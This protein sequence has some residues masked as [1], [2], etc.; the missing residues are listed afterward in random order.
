MSM[1]LENEYAEIMLRLLL[2]QDRERLSFLRL[3]KD[4]KWD[5]FLELAQE[6]RVLLRIYDRLVKLGVHPA[7]PYQKAVNEERE[8]IERTIELMG[9]IS[10][11]C[12]GE[13]IDFIFMKNYQH[14]PDM[15]EDIDLL[16]MDQI[17]IADSVLTER[18]G[19]KPFKRSILNRIGGKTQYSIDGYP[20]D[21]EIHHGRLSPMGDQI[22]YPSFLMRNRKTIR[23]GNE[24]L[25]V[26]SREDQF[27]VQ[28]L[29]RVYGRF[30]IR[31]SEIIYAINAIY[32][33]TFDWD[34]IFKTA[35]SI[36]IFYGLRFY[37]NY[38]NL[39]YRN[40]MNKSLPLSKYKFSKSGFSFEL[41]FNKL[42]YR[43]PLITV[44]RKI[45]IKKILSDIRAS[46]WKPVGRIC[47]L[48]F[49]AAIFTYKSIV[50]RCG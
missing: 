7:G 12:E 48:P 44:A 10:D 46:R 19:A 40:V 6:N 45:Y 32:I 20:S 42:H 28:V 31:I 13:G 9:K 37:L 1:V 34:Y 35:K 33:E 24:Q 26:P 18:L 36:G 8:R 25:F 21:L 17:D 41:R 4:V 23:I 11:I 3:L 16:V 5:V 50:R 27:I 30:N 15:G 2:E 39:I 49:F 29:Q 14:Y 43:I 38:I 22:E 47:L